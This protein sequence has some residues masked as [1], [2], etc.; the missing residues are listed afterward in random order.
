MD[1]LVAVLKETTDAQFQLD[2]LKGMNEGLKGRRE[3]QAPAGWDEVESKLAQSSNAEVRTLTQTLSLKFGS[4]S[5]MTALR[6]DLLNPALDEAKREAALTSLLASRDPSLA[7]DLLTLLAD[8][9]LRGAALRGLAAYDEPRAPAAILGLYPSLNA[10][11]KR[12][13][14]STLV[15]RVNFARALLAAIPANQVPARDL[16]AD[17]VR[18]LRDLQDEALNQQVEKHWGVIRSTPAEKQQEIARYKQLFQAVPKEKLDLE[19]GRAIFARTCQQCHTLF[20]VGGK[21]GPDI[22]GSNRADLDYIL[23]NILD[24]NAEI[25][26]DYRTVTIDTKD[27][28]VISGIVTREDGVSVTVA[29]ANE[30]IILPKPDILTRRQSELSMMPEGLVATLNETEVRDL[31]AYLASPAQTPLLATP[32]TVGG[33]FDGKTLDGWSGNLELWRVENGEIVGR[34]PGLQKNEFLVSPLSVGDFR[35]TVQVK[36]TPDAGNS[37]IQFRSAVEPSGS[38][39]GYQADVGAGWWGKL[40]EEHGRALLW[41][42]SGEAHVKREG[43]NTYEIVAVGSRI[44]TAINGKKCADLDDSKGARRGIF[45]FQLHSGGPMEVRFKDLKLDLNPTPELATR[46]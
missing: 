30:T 35:F 3:V 9:S 10:A 27:D 37:G 33:L 2:V 1:A 11:E 29:T 32:D 24:P 44:L 28:R 20:G 23:H 25:P 38:V 18:Q 43:W 31:I 13:A 12:D 7:A 15:S 26:N 5:A 21:V 36:L 34:S 41:D 8:A 6:K 19:H 42:Q 22:T 4:R 46:P 17:L 45:A 40:Y 16:S 14:L 39:K